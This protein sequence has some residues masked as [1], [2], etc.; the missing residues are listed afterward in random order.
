[1]HGD[2]YEPP[3][4]IEKK[5]AIWSMVLNPYIPQRTKTM[6]VNVDRN[7]NPFKGAGVNKVSVRNVNDL[8]PTRQGEIGITLL[9]PLRM[10]TIV[11]HYTS[12]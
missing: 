4:N 6:Q 11:T 10:D 9:S 7:S 2:M 5:Y 8:M 1:M 12:S 3:T